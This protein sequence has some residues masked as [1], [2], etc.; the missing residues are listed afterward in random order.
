MTPE[1]VAV[2]DQLK[3]I[4]HAKAREEDF[5]PIHLGIDWTSATLWCDKMSDKDIRKQ[6]LKGAITATQTKGDAWLGF[7]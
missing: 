1:Q 6:I 4:I 7:I 3:T 2:L 5:M